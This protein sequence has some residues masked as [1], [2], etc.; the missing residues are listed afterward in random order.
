[1]SVGLGKMK[2]IKYL[3]ISILLSGLLWQTVTSDSKQYSSNAIESRYNNQLLKIDIEKSSDDNINIR[4]HTSK[5]YSVPITPIKRSDNEYLLFLPETYH[6]VTSRPDISAY[7][8]YLNNVDIKL[9]PYTSSDSNNGYTRILI[10]TSKENVRLNVDNEVS[11]ADLQLQEEL[12]KIL[13]S[14]TSLQLR[15]KKT[16]SVKNNSVKT[17]KPVPRTAVSSA[18][19]AIKSATRTVSKSTVTATKTVSNSPV[20]T[21]NINNKTAPVTTKTTQ[22]ISKKSPEGDPGK[23]IPI[24]QTKNN[25]KIKD[26]NKAVNSAKVVSLPVTTDN[27]TSKV[28]INANSTTPEAANQKDIVINETVAANETVINADNA[29]SKESPVI[30]KDKTNSAI[31]QATAETPE[32]MKKPG[33]VALFIKILI[34]V[35]IFIIL[36]L[37]IVKIIKKLNSRQNDRPIKIDSQEFNEDN[38]QEEPQESMQQEIPAN[39]VQ[40]PSLLQENKPRTQSQPGEDLIAKL[41]QNP[42]K[43]TKSPLRQR[44][45]T[46]ISPEEL[47]GEKF[48]NLKNKKSSMDK[49]DPSDLEFITGVEVENQKGFYLVQIENQ[50]A[51]IGVIGSEIFLLNKF[52]RITSAKFSVRKTAQEDAQGKEVYFVRVGN[53]SGL[54]SSKEN[55]MSLETVF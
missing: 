54:V 13:S 15:P 29:T 16:H 21:V 47:D 46:E 32:K 55:E 19:P 42:I 20:K 50:K 37:A 11:K 1:M 34:P 17:T 28:N 4:L 41:A 45:Y 30:L 43:P 2:K 39:E 9:I 12:S 6:S 36:I 52:D 7:S 33:N 53:W 26:E 24:N 8:E 31:V 44:E 5:P 38:Y 35:F 48:L 18:R 27:T 23:L 14:K 49:K 25:E 22:N 10:R 51:L 3:I 40:Q